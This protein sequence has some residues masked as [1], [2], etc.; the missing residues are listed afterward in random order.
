MPYSSSTR[1]WL[2]PLDFWFPLCACEVV[3][4]EAA[5]ELEGVALEER[6]F[7]FKPVESAY[8]GDVGALRFGAIVDA[9]AEKYCRVQEE[10]LN[11]GSGR[12]ENVESKADVLLRNTA[13]PIDLPMR[14]CIGWQKSVRNW[15]QRE[16]GEDAS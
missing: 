16:N 4:F 10:I 14:R 15:F 12:C 6:L 2:N 1:V 11:F 9:M 5:F 13:A 3:P 7:D 8:G